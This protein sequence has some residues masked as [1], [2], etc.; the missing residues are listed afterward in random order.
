MAGSTKKPQSFSPVYKHQ[1]TFRHDLFKADVAKMKKN[2][3]YTFGHPRIEEIEHVHHYHSHNSFGKPQKYTNTVG[4][5]FHEVTFDP[6]TNKISCGP[7]LQSKSKKLKTGRIKQ[8]IETVQFYDEMSDAEGRADYIVDKHTH[9]MVYKF[10]EEL[11]PKQHTQVSAGQF[12]KTNSEEEQ[13][14]S[15]DI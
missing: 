14:A 1:L 6:Q 8:V 5:H 11:S 10:S 13:S 4:G 12:Q 15:A 3:S 7:P 9:E 2:V